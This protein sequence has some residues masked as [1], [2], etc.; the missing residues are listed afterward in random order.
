MAFR[1]LKNKH[2]SFKQIILVLE[3]N[4]T[5]NLFAAKKIAPSIL[6]LFGSSHDIVLQTN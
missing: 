4:A 6:P 3:D 2:K 1:R 5:S